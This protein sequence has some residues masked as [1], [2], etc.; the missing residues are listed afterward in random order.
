MSA[1]PAV[2]PDRKI[3]RDDIEAK[4]QELRGEVDQ[5]TEAAKVPGD[6][7]RGRRRGRDDR[8]RVPPRP[9][10]GEAAP[11]GA[12]DPAHLMFETLLRRLTH[13]RMAPGPSRLAHAGSI[14]ASVAGGLRLL[15]YVTRDHE[16][17]PLPH[18]RRGRRSVR[19]HHEGPRASDNRPAPRRYPSRR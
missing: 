5:R 16:E 19:D 12:R 8:R 11:D 10:Q 15:R 1:K 13:H 4:L 7:D 9:P 18:A 6:R 14:V 3:T 17:S 2:L